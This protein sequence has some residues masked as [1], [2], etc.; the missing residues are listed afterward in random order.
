VA[1]TV[2][3]ANRRCGGDLTVTTERIDVLGQGGA[4]RAR[5]REAGAV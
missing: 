4:E 3:V 5:V 1:K 2:V